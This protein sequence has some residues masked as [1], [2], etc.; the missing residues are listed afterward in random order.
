MKHRRI[1]IKGLT[2]EGTFTAR[3]SSYGKI[4]QGNDLVEP[5]AYKKTLI[6][7]K[8]SIPLLWQHDETFPIG[9]LD[10]EDGPD[11]LDCKGSLLMELPKAKEAYLLIKNNIINGMS[12]GFQTIKK[13][14][15][16]VVRRLKEIRLFEGSIVT[17]PMDTTALISAVKRSRSGREQKDLFAEEWA[18][19]QLRSAAYGMPYALIDSLCD[20]LYDQ[21]MSRDERISAAQTS[22]DQ[23]S[24]A[25]MAFIPQFLDMQA[26][27]A[28]EN[29]YGMGYWSK[30]VAEFKKGARHSAVDK[31]KLEDA[32]NLLNALLESEAGEES[33]TPEDAAANKSEPAPDHSAAFTL[34]DSITSLIPAA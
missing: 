6:E 12:I 9:R 7:N 14:M 19:A 25:Y 4:D 24:E 18:E 16:G 26:K 34:I 33:P 13:E 17:F 31:A 1:E 21:E 11:G 20:C 22:I 23:F 2:E 28:M 5:T 32:R 3:L 27:E 29:P 30:R 10:L 15:D 8:F